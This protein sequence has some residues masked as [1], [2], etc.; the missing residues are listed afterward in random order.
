MFSGNFKTALANLRS[1]KWRSILTMLGVIIGVTS[2]ITVV[3]LGEG[4]KA[5]V[6]GQINRLGSDVVTVRPGQLLSSQTSS[7]GASFLA[8]LSPSTLTPLDFSSITQLPS[9]SAAAPLEFVTSNVSSDN[10]QLDNAPVIGT[11]PELVSLLSLQINYGGFIEAQSQDQNLAVIGSGVA[12]QLFREFNPVGHSI[13]ILGQNFIIRGVLKPS[14]GGLFSLWQSDLN[15]TVFIA[16]SRAEALAAGHP[17]I[18]QIMALSKN[19]RQ[20]EITVN[21]IKN[22]LL[23]NHHGQPDFSVLKQQELLNLAGGVLNTLTDFITGLAAISLLVGGIGIMD[24][25]L[26]SVSERTR[27]IGIRKA[28]GAT[29]RQILS[30]FLVEGIVLSVGGGIIGIIVSLL[31]N[32]ILRFYTNLH[33]VVTVPVVILAALVSVA[34]GVIFSLAPAFKASRKSPIEALRG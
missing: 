14:S 12:N 5:Q 7:G 15:S 20:P 28:L 23:I 19:S 25:M 16:A 6:V 8:L 1:S 2:V 18:L 32:L 31:I 3:S 29:N 9:V 13:N 27:E 24:I 17:N 34:I 10:A 33:P 26:A 21:D 11:T 22:R 4:L 30:Q